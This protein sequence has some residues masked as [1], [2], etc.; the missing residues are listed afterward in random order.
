MT[1]AKY[2]AMLKPGEEH[3]CLYISKPLDPE[4]C[5]EILNSL[6]FDHLVRRLKETGK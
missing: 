2:Q 5:Y 6:A 1:E 3:S 4:K